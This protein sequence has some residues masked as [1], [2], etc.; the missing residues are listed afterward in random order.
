MKNNGVDRPIKINHPNIDLGDTL[1]DHVQEKVLHVA[2]TYFGHL[3][4][5]T[6]GFTRQGYAY[7]CTINLQV[8]ALR[9]F[10]A[11]ASAAD[12]QQ[13]FDQALAKV[14]KQL[15]RR[16]QRTLDTNRNQTSAPALA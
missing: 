3:N 14:D 11:D 16:K 1:T 15:R 10:V 8:G 12:C 6:V 2:G 5:G 13:A 4:H 7:A 9:M